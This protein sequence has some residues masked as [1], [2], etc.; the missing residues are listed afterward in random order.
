[1]SAKAKKQATLGVPAQPQVNLLPPE[2]RAS[3]SLT[4]TK[5]V[6]GLVMVGVLGLVG[7]LYVLATWQL[8]GA[9]AE[10][11]A[12]QDE[13][14]RLLREQQ[15]YSEVPQ[16]LGQLTLASTARQLGTTGEILWNP[17]LPALWATAPA[18]CEFQEVTMTGRTPTTLAPPDPNP[19]NPFSTATINFVARS[20]TAPD[21]AAW[22]ESLEQVDNF[23]GAYVTSAIITEGT[24]DSWLGVIYY[25]VTGTV[26]VTDAALANRYPVGGN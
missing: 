5:R 24:V 14:Q 23:T 2:I 20:L 7:V 11:T 13:T 8:N 16:V 4:A 26:Q 6:L 9:R 22:T 17:Y 1:M 12:A 10:L 3:R 19:L 21:V 15:Q 25:E 18:G